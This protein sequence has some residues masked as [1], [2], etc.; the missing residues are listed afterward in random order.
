MQ[1]VL[2][3]SVVEKVDLNRYKLTLRAVTYLML[4]F[5]G[6][7]FRQYNDVAELAQDVTIVHHT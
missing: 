5:G 3:L 4:N 6:S 1:V 7:S 2:T